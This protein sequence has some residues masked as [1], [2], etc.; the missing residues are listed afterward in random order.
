MAAFV[1]FWRVL[2]AEESCRTIRGRVRSGYTL[3]LDISEGENRGGGRGKKDSNNCWSKNIDSK[4]SR[5]F[6]CTPKHKAYWFSSRVLSFPALFSN[7]LAVSFL[8][9]SRRVPLSLS[10]FLSL[11]FVR[12]LSPSFTRTNPLP[13]GKSSI[14]DSSLRESFIRTLLTRSFSSFLFFCFCIY[15]YYPRIG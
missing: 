8:S 3:A 4:L 9:R 1:R 12:S 15:H 6:N 11:S 14:T 2:H 7:R 5:P 13:R 10:F